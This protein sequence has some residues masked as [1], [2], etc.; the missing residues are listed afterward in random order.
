M[1]QLPKPLALPCLQSISCQA[2]FPHH[3]LSIS[4][5]QHFLWAP[6]SNADGIFEGVSPH[7]LQN[8]AFSFP[9]GQRA[10]D[11]GGKEI[12]T[13]GLLRLGWSQL[14]WEHEELMSHW[15]L[16]L[17]VPFLEHT[18][19]GA[20][21][22]KA[23]WGFGF[24]PSQQPLRHTQSSLQMGGIYFLFLIPELLYT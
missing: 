15:D 23:D 3:L 4:G 17:L 13:R 18:F 8:E 24:F 2:F 16:P 21:Q 19:H 5:T 6:C 10:A 20:G 7:L 9:Y 14:A 1:C 12:I 11:G 22:G